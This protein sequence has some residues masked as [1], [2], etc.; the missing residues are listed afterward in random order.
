MQI[1]KTALEGGALEKPYL[2]MSDLQHALEKT[3]DDQIRCELIILIAR[4]HANARLVQGLDPQEAENAEAAVNAA[5]RAARMALAKVE[6][7]TLQ[8]DAMT[9][10]LLGWRPD[11]AKEFGPLLSLC[12]AEKI[13]DGSLFSHPN[14]NSII[15]IYVVDFLSDLPK[16]EQAAWWAK[17]M[18]SPL[19]SAIQQ[20]GGSWNDG[21]WPLQLLAASYAHPLDDS[22]RETLVANMQKALEKGGSSLSA[23]EF[24]QLCQQLK[25]SDLPF[26]A[27]GF[28]TQAREQQE[29]AERS[30]RGN[31]SRSSHSSHS[32]DSSNCT[33]S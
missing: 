24:A 30:K 8:L 5:L 18:C 15:S 22:I 31:S 20:F 32:S 19:Y 16:D 4:L 6:S 2:L 1:A 11:D 33:V 26:R 29:N 9:A 12:V 3:A 10:E 13:V 23:D 7:P 28:W 14:L 27:L 17:I 21:P 25:R